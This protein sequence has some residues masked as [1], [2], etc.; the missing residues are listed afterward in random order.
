MR[1]RIGDFFSQWQYSTSVAVDYL[2][3]FAFSENGI[4]SGN[5]ECN[6]KKKEK[7]PTDL[8]VVLN[9]WLKCYFGYFDGYVYYAM[10]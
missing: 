6:Y 7:K 3:C 1:I 10:R 2:F 5:I 9:A 8:F 4:L